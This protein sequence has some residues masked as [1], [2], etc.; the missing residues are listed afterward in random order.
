MQIGYN[1]FEKIKRKRE[2]EGKISFESTEIYFELDENS[3]PISVKKRKSNSMHEFIE[4]YMVLANETVAKFCKRRKIPFLSR[5]HEAPAIEN[6]KF[7]RD[8]L[9]KK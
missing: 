9:I 4:I 2:E 1:L 8:F 5:V 7:I 6:Q 3:H